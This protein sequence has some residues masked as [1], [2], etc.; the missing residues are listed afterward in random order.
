[1]KAS[2]TFK[3]PTLGDDGPD[4]KETEEFYDKREDL[5]RLAND[6]Q[7]MTPLEHLTTLFSC[8][9]G[10]NEKIYKS[11]HKKHRRLGTVE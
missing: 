8:L 3:W 5:C 1:M 10:S 2:P 9:K 7:G 6:G 11:T 4:S